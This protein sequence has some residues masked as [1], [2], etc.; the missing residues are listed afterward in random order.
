MNLPFVSFPSIR[1]RSLKVSVVPNFVLYYFY[2]LVVARYS[3]RMETNKK[4]MDPFSKIK[5]VIES[6]VEI[7]QKI[8]IISPVKTFIKKGV[9]G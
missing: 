4:F 1:K 6:S 3:D 9:L 2:L 7:G 5:V 8:F